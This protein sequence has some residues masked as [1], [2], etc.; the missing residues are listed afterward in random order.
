MDALLRRE[1]AITAAALSAMTVLAWLFVVRH[2]GYTSEVAL[3]SMA[4]MASVTPASSPWTM[5]E[6]ALSF[7]MW[8]VMMV[9]MMLPTA[10]PMILVFVTINRQ[11]GQ[12]G[13]ASFVIGTFLVGYLLVWIGFSLVAALG[14]LALQSAALLS[15]QTLTVTPFVGGALLIVAGVYQLSP[16][17]H[18]CLSRCQSPFAFLLA[19]WRDGWR[20][21]LLMGLRH[22]AFCVGCCWMLMALLFAAG[23][24]NLVWCA[25]ITAFTL[26]EKLVSG[27]LVSYTSSFLLV[28]F[29]GWLVVRNL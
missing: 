13:T 15:P 2:A 24:M 3:P 22:G 9:A 26:L 29:G 5:A 25:A 8:T 10:A 18:A 20:G 11:R 16:L 6:I 17:K 19:E 4:S 23:V 28:V 7:S 12:S 21:T 1:R 14:Q 27:R